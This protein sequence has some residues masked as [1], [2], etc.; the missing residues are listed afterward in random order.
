[1]MED[2]V[3]CQ[4]SVIREPSAAKPH[5]EADG[6]TATTEPQVVKRTITLTQKAWL[7]KIDTLQQVRKSKLSKASN[8]KR[9]IQSLM[10]DRE[11]EAEVRSTFEK[12]KCLCNDAKET[13]ESLLKLLPPEEQEKHETWFRAKLLNVNDFI[14]DANKWLSKTS[15]SIPTKDGY[16]NDGEESEIKPVDSISNIETNVSENKS[17][18]RS[19]ATSRSSGSSASSARLQAEA[20]RAAL[21]ARAAALKE[22]HAL[23]EQ[24]ELLRKK[25]ERLDLETEMA[26]TTAKIAVL[27][28]AGHQ[29]SSD[30]KANGMESYFEKATKF[31]EPSSTL[32]PAYQPTHVEQL[33]LQQQ[34]QQTHNNETTAI[35]N[36]LQRQNE[37][38]TLLINQQTSHLLPP[39]EI[40]YFDGDPLQYRLFIRAFEHCVERN[41]SNKGDC[42]YFLEKYTRGQ[43][44]ELIRSCQHMAPD[45]GYAKAKQLLQ[46]HFGNEYKITAAYTEKA[47]SWPM[48][49][50]ED[51]KAL[52]A[53]ALFLREC[54]NAMEDLQYMKE[55]D[56]PTH[57]RTL[58]LKLPYKLRDKW[59]V[60]ACELMEK[61][62]QRAQFLDIVTFIEHQVRIVSDPIF[63]DIQNVQLN[64]G[65]KTFNKMKPQSKPKFR[66]DSFATTITNIDNTTL[67]ENIKS[68]QVQQQ[69]T[70][71]AKTTSICL[72]CSQ[73]HTLEQCPQLE[74]RTHKNKINF[75][76]EKGVCFGCLCTGHLSKD[77]DKR[78]TCKVCSQKH[79]SILH[80]KL[81]QSAEN[82]KYQLK[83]PTMSST[84]ISEKTCGH[85]G[86]GT[87]DGI[88]SILPVQVK[89]NNSDK[90]IQTYA[91]LDPGSTATFCSEQLMKRLNLNGRK[92][93]IRLRTMGSKASVF[94]HR[95]SGLEVA[96][97]TGKRFY[98]LPEVYTQE[99][100]P[101][102]MDN[103]IRGEELEKWTYLNGVRIPHIQ[104]DVELLIGTNASK[105]LEPWE[106][107]NSYGNGPYAIRTLLGWVINGPLQGCNDEQCVNG[108]PTATVNRISIESLAEL[109]KD[110]YRHDFNEKTSE[111]KEE[112]S[113]DEIKFLGIMETGKLQDGHYTLN[114]PFKKEEVS[115]PNNQCV[116]KQR[117]LGLKKRFE[118]NE[119]FHQEYNS[120]LTDVINK[121][122]AERVPEH[123]KERS[124]G[125]VWYIPH[126]GVYHPRKG[127]LR[128]VF[129]CGAEYK[130]K[131]EQPTSTRSLPH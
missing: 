66:G 128:V 107:I 75:L 112:M 5:S 1:M 98:G 99:R 121:G 47:L 42:L 29:A 88:L 85:T 61:H 15:M 21:V 36:L 131:S 108:E 109:L 28:C 119:K 97:L 33:T 14:V 84:L 102:S 34:Q 82:P 106:V 19:H 41:T 116:A 23:E 87:S 62:H 77:C 52:Q 93:Q 76:K 3:Q 79:P 40:P 122:Y 12:Y 124:D 58:I 127:S 95:L 69:S 2:D 80:I 68:K 78:L 11:Y 67:E 39:R 96:S 38:T 117:I 73:N 45:R 56:M 54:C 4:G 103:L 46:E 43:P 13:H 8:I 104:A 115:L 50:P 81:K 123:Q 91:F 16:C 60:T 101:V 17:N 6:S 57:M 35:C 129:D 26:A 9:T 27:T 86:A 44:R 83:Q 92:V 7:A 74:K 10:Q 111:D 32:N 110:Q 55:L 89:Y 49:K 22:K 71:S 90:I 126:H 118:K 59:R 48:V 70:P 18:H 30:S 51:V 120:F 53:Y 65:N 125:K 31:K 130:G 113:R 64:T 24:A 114:L 63:G 100:M 25:K 72:C 105:L 37:I 20:E 94:S